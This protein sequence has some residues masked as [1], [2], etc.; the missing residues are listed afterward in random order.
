MLSV[1][2]DQGF[3]GSEKGQRTPEKYCSSK[4]RQHS[5]ISQ[6]LVHFLKPGLPIP[7]SYSRLPSLHV[8]TAV[9]KSSS[10]TYPCKSSHCLP[11]QPTTYTFLLLIP[12]LSVNVC[13]FL[14]LINQTSTKTNSVFSIF[15]MLA[16][17]I[18]VC[19][20]LF[21]RAHLEFTCTH[22]PLQT[23]NQ[24]CTIHWDK[25]ISEDFF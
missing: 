8:C 1:P 3:D 2:T 24:S 10:A 15:V 17:D 6:F 5:G 21:L 19:A 7:T 25:I 11:R 9:P 20:P 16:E 22:Q 14:H 18:I 12:C 23:K 13:I 4:T